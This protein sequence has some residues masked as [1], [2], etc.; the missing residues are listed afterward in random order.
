MKRG[1][2]D[3]Y[4]SIN[5]HYVFGTR[6]RDPMITGELASRLPAFIGGIL[7]KNGIKAL[8]IG[9]MPDH[10]HMLVSLPASL[11]VSKAVQLAKG[12]SSKW[13]HDTFTR[14]RGFAWQ[15]GYGAFSVSPSRIPATIA[16]IRNQW[17]HHHKRSFMEEYVSFLK[18]SGIEYDERYL[19]R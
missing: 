2:A 12:G 1:M 7:R 14:K 6:D 19:W 13:I 9:V 18:K 10:V 11:A 5:I 4:H 8:C 15:K 16:Y 17:E 3:T